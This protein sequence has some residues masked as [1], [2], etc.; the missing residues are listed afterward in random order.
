MKKKILLFGSTG[1]IGIA[2]SRVLSKEYEL[3]KY[4][5][6]D[7]NLLD[8]KIVKDNILKICPD[9]I[10][11]AAAYTNVDLAEEEKEL[12][13][14]INSDAV[15]EM[16]K[17]A[18]LLDIIFIHFS[19]DYVFDGTSSIAY[20]ELS[21][22]NPINMYGISKLSGENL[23]V[24]NCN[25]YFI[26]RTSWVYSSEGDN[27]LNTMEKLFSSKN[28]ISVIDDQFGTP[29]HAV[30]I[31]NKILSVLRYIAKNENENL[32]NE[33]G[34]YNLSN[35]GKTSWY[36]FSCELL[37]KSKHR[38]TVKIVP[39]KSSE[40]LSKAMRPINTLLST[41]KFENTFKIKMHDWKFEL[42][43]NY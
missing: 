1:Q 12:A 15:G 3:I 11:N 18:E 2:L 29:N 30:G 17:A 33:Y 7:L 23:V 25:K 6:D 20:T 43:L 26:F 24:K 16:A 39:I 27:F 37:K 22:T 40:Y 4:S 32:N 8:T 28:Q 42:N 31:S 21:N 36:L 35:T 9:I 41:D 13:N 34:I 38:K 10:I 14:L 5:R 19:T